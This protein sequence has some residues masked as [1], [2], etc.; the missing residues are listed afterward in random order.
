[1]ETGARQEISPGGFA[2]GDPGENPGAGEVYFG[3]VT[4]VNFVEIG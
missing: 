1:M 4:R 2:E 3:V